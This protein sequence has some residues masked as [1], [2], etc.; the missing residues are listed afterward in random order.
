MRHKYLLDRVLAREIPHLMGIP[1]LK[2]RSIASLSS[3]AWFLY[4]SSGHKKNYYFLTKK[5]GGQKATKA[6][7]KECNMGRASPS[8]THPL[9]KD[10]D[11]E[12]NLAPYVMCK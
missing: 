5:R 3:L 4:P 6:P 11:R 1:N 8:Y 12:T 2:L 7:Q 9:T 10:I